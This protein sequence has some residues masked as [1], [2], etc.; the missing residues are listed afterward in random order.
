MKLHAMFGYTAS[1]LLFWYALRTLFWPANT[2]PS[3]PRRVGGIRR[4]LNKNDPPH[5][6]DGVR[7]AAAVGAFCTL[8]LLSLTA[9]SGCAVYW[10]WDWSGILNPIIPPGVYLPAGSEWLKDF[11]EGCAT[12]VLIAATLHAVCALPFG[13][14]A[15]KNKSPS[16][17]LKRRASGYLLLLAVIIFWAWQW[18]TETLFVPGWSEVNMHHHHHYD[19][20]YYDDDD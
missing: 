9:F 16:I 5:R 7:Y 10:N 3:L 17:T 20:H 11:H 4:F 15:L 2:V 18:N 1:L 8:L 14:N 12:A 19:E 6:R 13:W